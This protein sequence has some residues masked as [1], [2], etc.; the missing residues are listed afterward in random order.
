MKRIERFLSALVAAVL[1]CCLFAPAS[2][3]TIQ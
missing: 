3:E 2:A 1:L